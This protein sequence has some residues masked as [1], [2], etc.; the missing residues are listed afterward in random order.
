MMKSGPVVLFPSDLNE[1]NL[2][3]A[4]TIYNQHDYLVSVDNPFF[5]VAILMIGLASHIMTEH[6]L[7][8]RDDCVLWS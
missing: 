2:Q 6:C 7:D 5:R 4:E 8:R 1:T 3:C